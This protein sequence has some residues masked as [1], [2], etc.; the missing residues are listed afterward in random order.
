MNPNLAIVEPVS[1]THTE[2]LVTAFLAGRSKNTRD[3]YSRDLKDFCTWTGAGSN[4]EAAQ[5]LLAHGH[6]QA[7]RIVLAYKAHLIEE[8]CLQAPTVNR[9][10]AALRS[11]VKFARTIGVVPWTLEVGNLKTEPYR[12]TAGP[13]VQGLRLLLDQTKGSKPKQIR[14]RAILHLLY[15]L[16]LRRGEVVNLDV[17]DVR[18]DEAALWVLGKGRLQKQRLSA[19]TPTTAALIAWLEA[20]GPE[21]GP[22][23]LNFDRSGK[24]ERLTGTSVYRIVRG[25]GEKA[26]IKVTPHGLRHTAVTEAVKQAQ[27]NGYG[28][29]EVRDFSRH[30]SVATLMVYRDRERNIQGQLAALVAGAI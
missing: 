27:A 25:L 24:G 8:R 22:L 13:S 28:I 29:E 20:R 6:G 17:E 11:L 2:A 3:A 10:L 1:L 26:G 18:I 19:P 7:N 12:D 23:F 9:R 4:E 14:D 15:D 30:S 21:A 5:L 16:G